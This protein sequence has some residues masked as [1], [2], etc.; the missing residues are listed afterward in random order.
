M[1]DELNTGTPAAPA[2]P[3]APMPSMLVGTEPTNATPAGTPGEPPAAPNGDAGDPPG[4]QPAGAPETY[5]E[6]VMPEGVTADSEAVAAF[7]E[8]A[9]GDN[10]SQEKAQAYV[11][12][13][14]K[15]VAEAHQAAQEAA[16]DQWNGMIAQWVEELKTDSEFGGEKLPEAMSVAQRAISTFG[17][18]ALKKVLVETGMTN[19]PALF[20]AFWKAGLTLSPDTLHTGRGATKPD[21]GMYGYMNQKPQ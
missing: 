5:G 18:E 16:V 8:M 21:G 11:D 9:K 4:E 20:R 15:L 17:D 2:E 13:A 10:L 14:S 19:N 6:F 7:V 12:L 1:A 3:A